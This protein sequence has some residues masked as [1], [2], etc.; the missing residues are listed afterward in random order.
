LVQGIWVALAGRLGYLV[1][2][3]A[4]LWVADCC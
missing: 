2:V 1:E 4:G 3:C